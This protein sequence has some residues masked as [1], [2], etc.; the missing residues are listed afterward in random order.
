MEH[1]MSHE[2]AIEQGIELLK[3]CQRLQSE[4]DGVVRPEPGVIDM[5][6][7]L[8]QFAMNVTEAISYMTSLHSLLPMKMQ[9]TELG[10]ALERQGKIKPGYGDDYADAALGYLLAAHGLAPAKQSTNPA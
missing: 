5:A 10:R 8:D 4:K 6:A 9:L 1:Q 7:T 2:K 3:L